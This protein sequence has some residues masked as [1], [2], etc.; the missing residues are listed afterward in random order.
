M[1]EPITSSIIFGQEKFSSMTS[2]PFS[3]HCRA[4]SS[5]SGSSRPINEATI[6]LFGYAFFSL[7]N[8]ARFSDTL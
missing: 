3:S 1:A 8:V 6:T 4:K 2:A 5:H 7:R